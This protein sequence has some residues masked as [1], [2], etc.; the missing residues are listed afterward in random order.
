MAG[1]HMGGISYSNAASPTGAGKSYPPVYPGTRRDRAY[2]EGRWAGTTDPYPTA[3]NPH[4]NG[5]PNTLLYNAWESGSFSEAFGNTDKIQTGI[6]A[7]A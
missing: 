4:T 5:G 3:G 7:V 6:D 2:A 1:K